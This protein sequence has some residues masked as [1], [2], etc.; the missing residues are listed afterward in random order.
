M[1]N[2]RVWK[3]PGLASLKVPCPSFPWSF[4]KDQ[5]KPQKHQGFFS[6][7]EPLKTP[8]NKQ[9]TLKKTKEFHSK[10]N[11]KET[12]TPRKRRTGYPRC[13]IA[14]D[15]GRAMRATKCGTIAAIP[16]IARDFSREVSTLPKWCDTP[17][18]FSVSHRHISAIPHFATYRAMI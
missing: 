16:H 1:G 3:H 8:E 2:T 11:T 10:K 15:A 13:Q 17:P 5:G 12:K 14:S 9:K 4:R 18:W 6:A 7:S